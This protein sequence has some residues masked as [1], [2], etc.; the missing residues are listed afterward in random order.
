VEEFSVAPLCNKKVNNLCGCREK[1]YKLRLTTKAFKLSYNYIN[2][3]IN[4]VGRSFDKWR[5]RRLRS[6]G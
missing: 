6:G 3:A 2:C 1:G 5:R 4:L